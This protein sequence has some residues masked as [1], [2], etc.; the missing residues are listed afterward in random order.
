MLFVWVSVL[1]VPLVVIS[2]VIYLV[3]T[4]IGLD[5]LT[6]CITKVHMR[7]SD[8]AGFDFEISDTDCDEIAKEEWISVFASKAGQADKTLVFE[9]DPG[10]GDPFPVITLV[11]RHSVRISVPWISSIRFR[12]DSLKGLSV[13]YKI[14][15]VDYPEAEPNQH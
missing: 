8:L 1:T 13:V 11:D 2:L 7:L 3:L 12:R 10:G 5:P 9:Y 4:G 14:N 6:A 15:K